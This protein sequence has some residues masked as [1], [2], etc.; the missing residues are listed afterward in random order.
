MKDLLNWIQSTELQSFPPDKQ[1][2]DMSHLLV[3]TGKQAL[4]LTF[5]L[6]HYD[7]GDT[8]TCSLAVP[9]GSKEDEK[10]TA[11]SDAHG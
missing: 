6:Q 4:V 8:C 10:P 11:T 2:V 9:Q 1:R 5:M 7:T 3:K